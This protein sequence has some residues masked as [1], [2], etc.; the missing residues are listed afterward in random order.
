MTQQHT[1]GPW[2]WVNGDTD[3]P[4]D[5]KDGWNRF[6]W[7]SLRSVNLY[8]ENKTDVINGE[9]FTSWALPMWILDAEPMQNG[10]DDAN[11]RLIAASPLMY[12]FIK[13]MASIGNQDA[14]KILGGIHA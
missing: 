2:H 1:P 13:N 5:F 14:I 6:G 4:I 3:K 10:N 9:S 11:A 7:V 8:G 12:D